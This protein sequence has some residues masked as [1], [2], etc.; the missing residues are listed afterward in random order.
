MVLLNSQRW[1]ITRPSASA[2]KTGCVQ[3][4][5]Q[6]EIGR[7]SPAAAH[8]PL[9][10]T[11]SHQC[12]RPCQYE[13]SHSRRSLGSYPRAG[14]RKVWP[15]RCSHESHHAPRG[16]AASWRNWERRVP[17]H[18]ERIGRSGGEIGHGYTERFRRT[19]FGQ[20]APLPIVS[21]LRRAA[22]RACD[23]RFGAR[24]KSGYVELR[25]PEPDPHC[26]FVRGEEP[27]GYAWLW[28]P[29]QVNGSVAIEAR[30]WRLRFCTEATALPEIFEHYFD[31]AWRR[32]PS[33]RTVGVR[34]SNASV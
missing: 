33:W 3:D 16:R 23:K 11:L 8:S 19:R 28:K 14:R 18:R 13:R 1:P 2:H 27:H 34:P 30:C 7:G 32:I 12:V 9:E 17:A 21:R 24:S 22:W 31:Y 4:P 20:L 15:Y 6:K 29:L 26:W 25:A 5:R 10:G